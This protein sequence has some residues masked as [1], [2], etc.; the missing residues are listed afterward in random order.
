[1]KIINL[2][3]KNLFFI[4]GIVRDELIGTKNFDIDITYAGNAIEFAKTIP[5]AEILQVNE[6]F[7][8]VRIKLDGEEIDIASTRYETYPQKGHLPFVENIGCS[9]KEDILRR[10]F[11]INAMAKNTLTSEIIDYTTGL[12]DIKNK[13][14]RVLHD[15]SFIDDPT[16]IVRGL[17]FSVRF[18]FELDEH[19]KKLQDEYLKNINYDMSYKRLKKELIE[20]FNLNSNKAFEKFVNEKIY[21]LIAPQE[22][23]LPKI[24]LEK[25]ITQH[26]PNYPWIIY[27]G[28][29]PDI[30]NLPLTKQEKKIVEDF[31]NLKHKTF[32]SDFEIYKTFTNLN[33]ESIIM[34]ATIA[35]KIT[36]KYFDKLQNIKLEITGAQLQEL[37]ISPSE[38]YQKCFDFIL[39]HKIENPQITKPEEIQLAKK[40]FNII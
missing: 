10:D 27:I 38:E 21:K 26:N 15:N 30:S 5:D 13:K 40:Y 12:E 32:N 31:Q 18:G 23:N 19:T 25:L 17:K 4:G 11:T 8:T 22:F 14:L 34:Y 20:T 28:L 6:P 16:R 37:G 3:Y 1:M 7:G 9:L 39:T 33:P 36:E 35:P 24:N 2:K 29:L